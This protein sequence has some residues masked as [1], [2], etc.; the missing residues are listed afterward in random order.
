MMRGSDDARGGSQTKYR[1]KNKHVQA[2]KTIHNNV[3]GFLA[4]GAAHRMLLGRYELPRG[5]TDRF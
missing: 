1:A 2:P 5:I 4:L 3:I